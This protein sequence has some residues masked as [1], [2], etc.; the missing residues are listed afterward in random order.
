MAGPIIHRKPAEQ[1]DI[2][3]PG[4]IF[5]GNDDHDGQNGGQNQIIEGDGYGRPHPFDLT[6]VT[7][8]FDVLQK[9]KG[10]QHIIPD[11]PESD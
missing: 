2:Q 1:E 8:Q 9:I 11:Q 10:R 3:Q 5:S 7:P 6:A 4:Q